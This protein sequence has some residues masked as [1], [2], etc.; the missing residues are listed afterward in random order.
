MSKIALAV[1]LG[2]ASSMVGAQTVYKCTKADGSVTFS[3][4]PCGKDAK[5]VMGNSPTSKDASAGENH[6]AKSPA[7]QP[8]TDPNIQA[9]SD[10]VDDANCRRDAQR[11]ATPVPSTERIDQARAELAQLQPQAGAASAE[12]A[13]SD[14]SQ[15]VG[16]PY[17]QQIADLNEFISSEQAR[18]S[19]LAADSQKKVE[20][21]LA[22]CDRKKTEREAAHK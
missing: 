2:I 1:L 10:S 8:A 14:Y 11:L 12:N 3:Q 22:A 13:N 15:P 6:D 16:Q 19:A 5:V 4:S 20:E 7:S 21:A 17:A 9:I 18:I